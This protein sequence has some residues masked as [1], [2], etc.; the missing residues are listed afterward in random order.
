[1]KWV[2]KVCGYVHEGPQPPDI[3]PVCKV[4]ADK[5]EAL[6]GERVWADEHRLGVAKGLEESLINS[7]RTG[8]DS[9]AKD[10]SV[11]LAMAR[12]AEREGYAEV[13]CQFRHV[14]HE[15]AAHAARLAE[16]LGEMLSES[17]ENNLSMRAEA[18][19]A[20]CQD[21]RALADRAKELGYDALHDA[22]HE[23]CKDEARHGK[24]LEGL[25][26]RLFNG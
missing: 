16:L 26:K 11:Y 14:A 20:S 1:M 5:F 17:T 7:L 22:L 9:A 24:V 4:P 13:A 25:L 15:K 18:E 23:M 6:P 10:S 19:F 12:A 8:F 2:C 21:K 3:C